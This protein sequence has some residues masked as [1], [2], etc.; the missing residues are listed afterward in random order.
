MQDNVAIPMPANSD[1]FAS[2]A[3]SDNEKKT[4]NRNPTI[5]TPVIP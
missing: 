5:K 2:K 3:I 1:D 4:P